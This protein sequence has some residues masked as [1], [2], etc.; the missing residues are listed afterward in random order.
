[1]RRF[2]PPGAPVRGGGH[3]A[4]LEEAV[5]QQGAEADGR[6]RDAGDRRG[7]RRRPLRRLVH[8][9]VGAPFVDDAEQAV[10]SAEA[11]EAEF[12]SDECRRPPQIPGIEPGNG[13][14][15]HANCARS[16]KTARRSA[17]ECPFG[18]QAPK[19]TRYGEGRE[20][21]PPPASPAARPGTRT[22]PEVHEPRAEVRL[23]RPFGAWH[24]FGHGWRGGAARSPGGTC[25]SHADCAGSANPRADERQDDQSGARHRIRCMSS[26]GLGCRR[27]TRPPAA[28]SVP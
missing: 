2:E 25:A 6:V 14:A 19:Q 26:P 1:V 11:I 20:T 17:P 10:Q 7:D 18:C 28:R 15:G 13:H 5:R 9:H 8:D 4:G 24:P 12:A 3:G 22:A 16:V 21:T 23:D 27:E